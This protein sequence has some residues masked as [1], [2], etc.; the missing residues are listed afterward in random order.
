MGSQTVKHNWATSTT[1]NPRTNWELKYLV[2][3]VPV[4]WVLLWWSRQAKSVSSVTPWGLYSVRG[5]WNYGIILNVHFQVVSI[6][7][8][9]S[10]LDTK[11]RSQTEDL[12]PILENYHLDDIRRQLSIQIAWEQAFFGS[13]LGALNHVTEWLEGCWLR[14]IKREKEKMITMDEKAAS[15]SSC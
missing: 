10:F 5:L 11:F 3:R 9:F 2:V 12:L 15:G 13:S 8:R 14:H 4:A 7:K 6:F 1:H